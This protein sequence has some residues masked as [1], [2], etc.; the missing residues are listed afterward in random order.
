MTGGRFT[1]DEGWAECIQLLLL[2][3]RESRLEW[4]VSHGLA[5]VGTT[6]VISHGHVQSNGQQVPLKGTKRKLVKQ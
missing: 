4:H 1:G 3:P 5:H 2:I 6:R